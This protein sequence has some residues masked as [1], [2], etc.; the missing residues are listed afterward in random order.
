MQEVGNIASTLSKVIY[1]LIFKDRTKVA[2]DQ[3]GGS[4]SV[5]VSRRLFLE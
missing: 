2:N 5:S 4:A 1:M 3:V